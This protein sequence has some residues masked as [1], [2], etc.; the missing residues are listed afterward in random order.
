[1]GKIIHVVEKITDVLVKV[2]ALITAAVELVKLISSVL[3]R[4]KAASVG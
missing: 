2:S 3:S 4:N 1:M